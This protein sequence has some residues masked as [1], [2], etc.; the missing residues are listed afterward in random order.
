MLHEQPRFYGNQTIYTP[1]FTLGYT[2]IDIN[3]RTLKSPPHD[4]P[5]RGGAERERERE[6][7]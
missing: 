2:I 4:L 6:R 3:N 7:V 1:E 5:E